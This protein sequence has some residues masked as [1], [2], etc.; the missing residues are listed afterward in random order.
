VSESERVRERSDLKGMKGKRR[1][2]G[3]EE[4]EVISKK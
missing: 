4:K 2:E 3:T 1:F